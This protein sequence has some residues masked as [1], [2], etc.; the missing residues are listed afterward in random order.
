VEE[1]DTNSRS[2]GLKC[3]QFMANCTCYEEFNGLIQK[4]VFQQPLCPKD[5]ADISGVARLL[6]GPGRVITMATMAENRNYEL[7]GGKTQ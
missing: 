3:V 5:V 6:W 2:G 4:F 7:L 1:H